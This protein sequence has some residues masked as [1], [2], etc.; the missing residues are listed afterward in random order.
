VFFCF[1][2]CQSSV[3][4]FLWSAP[5]DDFPPKCTS[6]LAGRQ[7]PPRRPFKFAA[8]LTIPVSFVFW[9]ENLIKRDRAFAEMYATGTLRRFA[10]KQRQRAG[11]EALPTNLLQT[12]VF[13]RLVFLF[14][15]F[16]FHM[17]KLFFVFGDQFET[18]HFGY[19]ILRRDGN[20]EVVVVQLESNSAATTTNKNI[21]TQTTRCV[22]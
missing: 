8:T 16:L 21:Q 9:C 4:F 13:T 20:T 7:L 22:A 2:L 11:L 1:F 19:S 14:F 18:K 5:R 6:Y 3:F 10:N 12:C 17:R 15:V